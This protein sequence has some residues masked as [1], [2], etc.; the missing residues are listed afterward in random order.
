MATCRNEWNNSKQKLFSSNVCYIH[1]CMRHNQ[2]LLQRCWKHSLHNIHIDQKVVDQ[3]ELHQS[4]L[5]RQNAANRSPT[6]E[7]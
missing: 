1:N 4:S 3:L 6:G 2:L 5:S 7:E